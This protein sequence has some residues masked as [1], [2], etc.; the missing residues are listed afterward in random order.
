[1]NVLA[2]TNQLD[3]FREYFD[4]QPPCLSP[5]EYQ[6]NVNWNWEASTFWNSELNLNIFVLFEAEK[7]NEFRRSVSIRLQAK[8]RACYYLQTY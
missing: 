5:F 4:F 1:M 3:L 2:A 8:V 7:S 6:T